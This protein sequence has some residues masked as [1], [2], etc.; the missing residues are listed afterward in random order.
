MS[1]PESK[2]R[3]ITNESRGFQLRFPQNVGSN[4]NDPE[5]RKF[6]QFVFKHID[7]DN[8]ETKG[9]IVLPYPEINDAV[10]VKYNNV[11]L[12]V[13]GAVG[14]GA[15]VGNI[16]IEG[17]SRAA[18][19]G[20]RSFSKDSFA[21][22]AADVALNAT[23]GLKA[24]VAKGLNTIQNPYITNVFESTGFREFS[25][26]FT[27][28]PKNSIESTVIND[29]VRQFKASMLPRKNSFVTSPG[30]IKM[31]NSTGILKM[32]DK[33][34]IN[35]FA[36]TGDYEMRRRNQV[37]RI[38]DAV[39][40]GF[41]VEFSAGTKNPTFYQDTDAPL[42]ATLNVTVKETKIYTKE[43]C[44]ADYGALIEIGGNFDAARTDAR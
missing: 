4:T 15:G 26:V 40:T 24:G 35:F 11:Q 23:P 13:T 20:L 39:V 43:R 5:S 14:V 36:T 28:I 1:T 25:F 7:N 2:I 9:N 27:L 21:R 44:E 41:S 31:R 32:P 22:V 38:S 17:L 3:S 16:S 33:V 6:C 29:I 12:D 19:T 34:D 30:P 37:I 42:S 8:T 10:N 18:K